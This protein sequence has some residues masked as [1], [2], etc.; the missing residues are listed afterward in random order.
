MYRYMSPVKQK[1]ATL[2]SDP[3]RDNRIEVRRISVWGSHMVSP[4]HHS[5]CLDIRKFLIM[6]QKPRGSGG[7]APGKILIPY[8]LKIPFSVEPRHFHG[9]G[10]S[11]TSGKSWST[12]SQPTQCNVASLLARFRCNDHTVDDDPTVPMLPI[13]SDTKSILPIFLS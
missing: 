2:G 3:L 6:P 5:D 13:T 12:T 9:P 4:P 8:G 11:Q 7:S 10:S 1:R